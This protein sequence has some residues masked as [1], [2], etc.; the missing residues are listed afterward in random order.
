MREVNVVSRFHELLRFVPVN[1][2][3]ILKQAICGQ[4]ENIQEIVLRSGRP[5]CVYIKSRE[6]FLTQN[7]C[8]TDSIDSQPLVIA[9][10]KDITDCFNVSCGYS[11]YSHLN[12]IKAGFLTLNGGHRIGISGTAV[13][14]NDSIVNIR[15]ISTISIRFARE[16]VGCGE[17]IAA[18]LSLSREG[19][20]LC[21]SPC[22]GKTTVLRDVARLMS[23]K[24]RYRVTV[25][26]S[27]GEIGGTVDGIQQMDLGMCD[28][29][30]G[31]PRADGIEQAVRVLSPQYVV[32][33]ELGSDADVKA[34]VSGVNSGVRFI[35]TIHASSKEELLS[36]NNAVALLRTKAFENIV[37][38][39]GREDP[40]KISCSYDIGEIIDV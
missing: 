21:G 18:K 8:L 25:V 2:R 31:Y 15:D 5:V 12:E 1:I 22:S 40:G 24:Y 20:L 35:S 39:K 32:C 3:N 37:F 13:V 33:D 19:L 34:I 29:M 38:L 36:R 10:Q 27:R 9:Y 30:N 26:D 6:M 17:P 4:E 14:S 28:V 7:G 16:I 23:E 11:V